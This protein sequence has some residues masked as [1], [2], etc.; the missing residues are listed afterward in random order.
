VAVSG[1]SARD[2][3]ASRADI[4]FYSMQLLAYS[5]STLLSACG[6][7]SHLPMLTGVV[8]Q[9][10]RLRGGGGQG[11]EQIDQ[12]PLRKSVATE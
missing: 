11:R 3:V 2:G 12:S 9:I 6:W 10:A 8:P 7:N 1:H 5:A 4:P